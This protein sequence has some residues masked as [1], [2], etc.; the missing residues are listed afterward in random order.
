M[1]SAEPTQADREAAYAK[2][3]ADKL[4]NRGWR[5]NNLY[6]IEDADGKKVK[7]RMNWAQKAFFL[8]MWWLNVI[9]KA[10]QLG[11]STF[12]QVMMLDRCLFNPNQT[13]GIVDKTDDDA[14]KK[15]SRMEFAYDHLDDPDD[16]TTAPLGAAIKQAVRLLVSNKKE[17]E[18]SNGSKAW[19]GTSLRGGTVQFLHISELGYIAFFNPKKAKEIKTGALNTVH[20]GNIVVIES[21]HEGGKYGL[22]YDMVKLAQEAP[23]PDDLTEMDWRFHF[24]AWWRCPEYVLP[25]RGP[26]A[27]SRELDEYFAKI[28]KDDAITLTPEQ[29]HWYAKKHASQGDA[30]LKEF[31]STP[32]EALNA[33]VVGAI[34]GKIVSKLRRERRIV[35]F[36]HDPLQP[37]YTFWDIGY[38]DFCAIWLLQFVGRDI[39]AVAYYC[40]AGQT[41]AHYAAKCFEWERKYGQPILAHYLPH[42]ANRVEGMGSGKT[43][44]QFLEEAGLK[45][46]KIVPRTPDV[47]VGINQLRA[48]L[49]RFYIHKTD[50]GEEWM[51]EDR[52][53]PSGVAC[54]EAY[55]TEQDASSGVIKEMPV[56]DE[57]SHGASAL[58]TFAE[59]HSRGMLEGTTRLA[60]ERR[61]KREALTG[62]R[63]P[64]ANRGFTQQ[65]RAI[66]S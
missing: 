50:C 6:W 34:Y 7:F 10:R 42:D 3:I 12:M 55:H 58:R 13:C 66:T 49:N 47:W 56:H 1:S 40:N 35:D 51:M 39:C 16:P 60:G 61:E 19:A 25:L 53:M 21:T 9:L 43:T 27:L 26:L 33:V 17:L 18:W 14:K 45:N 46:C 30:M 28:E 38:S 64:H 8:G 32:E 23:Q 11:L 41:G 2:A 48:L 15:L 54:L 44:K 59:A 22:N 52:R 62:L 63:S 57:S 20:R 5:L 31:P 65:R 37:I 24:F 4:G 36:K 29:R